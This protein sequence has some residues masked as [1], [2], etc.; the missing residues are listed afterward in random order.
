MAS[1]L[2]SKAI[3]STAWPWLPIRELS[4]VVP[5]Y[6][7]IVKIRLVTVQRYWYSSLVI[8]GSPLE[9]LKGTYSRM[10]LTKLALQEYAVAC[11]LPTCLST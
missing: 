11:A 7:Y 8:D 10:V 3:G 9:F 2:I 5:S 6:L 4:S 1:T